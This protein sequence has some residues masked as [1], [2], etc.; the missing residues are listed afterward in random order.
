LDIYSTTAKALKQMETGEIEEGLAEKIIAS[1]YIPQLIRHVQIM[2]N[3][4]IDA[5]VKM[6]FKVE[7]VAQWD[8][9]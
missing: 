9:I 1:T 7:Q 2:Y 5:K 4:L 3:A 6:Y 8:G